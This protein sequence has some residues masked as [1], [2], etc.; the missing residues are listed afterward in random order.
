M[1]RPR[2]H[3]PIYEVVEDVADWGDRPAAKYTSDV[4]A[5]LKREAKLRES[6]VTLLTPTKASVAEAVYQE[7]LHPRDR[8]GK[9]ARK[10]GAP[11]KRVAR[12][13]SVPT[14]QRE[15]VSAR[16]WTDPPPPVGKKGESRGGRGYS[17]DEAYGT[18]TALGRVGEKAFVK[19]V[20]GR[21]LHPEGKGEQSPLDVHFDGYG[22]EV[23]AV[24]TKTLGY[25][26]TPKKYE[27]EQKE[28][29]AKELGVQA[30]LAIVVVDSDTGKAHA[31]FRDGLASGRLSQRR[32]WQYLGS[33]DLE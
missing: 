10:P 6:G 21:V 26:A 14:G 23:K 29:F 9:W 2:L 5:V 31:Y 22:F 1:A 8:R 28:Q 12:K 13:L 16:E 30:A 18:N 25:K 11:V 17:S 20:G 19:I 32:G 4:D 7:R 15:T 33:T 27:R 3:M 24:S